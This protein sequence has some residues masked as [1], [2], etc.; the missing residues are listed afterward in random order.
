MSFLDVNGNGVQD[1][2]E[3]GLNGAGVSLQLYKTVSGAPVKVGSPISPNTDGGVDGAFAFVGIDPNLE[4]R[5][6]P[7]SENDDV[8]FP[9]AALDADGFLKYVK[10]TDAAVNG[11]ENTA[12]YV[13]SST[14]KIGDEVG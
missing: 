12:Q 10:I 4:Y 11:S 2:G 8:T 6:K 5:V 7:I 9:A 14:F 13:G 3:V 1:A